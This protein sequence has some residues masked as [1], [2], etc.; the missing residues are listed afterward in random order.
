ML[1]NLSIKVKLISLITIFIVIFIGMNVF[2]DVSLNSQENKFTKMQTVVQIRGNVVGA[3]TSG[4][5]ITSALR[6]VYIN[7]KDHRTIE[8]LEKTVSKMEKY[9]KNLQAKKFLKISQGL[10]KFNIL[11][12][13]DRYDKDIKRLIVKFEAGDL[14]AQD[15]STHI[16]T[17][18]R[19]FKK[20][21]EKY[22]NT[23]K[24]KDTKMT[25]AYIEANSDIF[26]T[27]LVLTIVGVIIILVYSFMITNSIIGSLLKVQNGLVSFFDFLNRKSTQVQSIQIDTNDELGKMSN[28]INHN[29]LHIKDSLE[30]DKLFLEDVN[31]VMTRVSKGWLTQHIKADTDNENLSILKSTINNALENLKE[32]V[33]TINDVLEEYANEDYRK[34]LELNNIEKDGVFDTLVKDINK[35]QQAITNMLLQNKK[36]GTT[37]E[38]SSDVLLKNVS[39]LNKNSNEAAIALEETSAALEDVIG[40]IS[41]NTQNILKMSNFANDVTKS[42]S[43][44]QTLSS[45]TT[46]AMD[47]INEQVTAIND[48]ISVIDQISF[49]TN[50]LSLNAAVEAATAGEAG[51]GFAVVAQEVRNLASRSAEAANEIKT[52]VENA[53]EK[54]NNGKK[55]SD[56]MIAGY[57]VLNQSISNTLELIKDVEKTSKEQQA[58]ILQINDAVSS[59]DKQTQENASVAEQTNTIALQTDKMAKLVVSNVNKKK[60]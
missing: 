44:G 24:K 10:K 19:P 13:Y 20:A 8:N 36:N 6:G 37:L 11:P 32:N 46:T 12:L 50:I 55:I 25:D 56:K 58:S 16:V 33:V 21:L 15:I 9:I 57:E 3:L 51:K 39:V 59:L 48:A 38:K 47:E 49:Q 29:I 7:S 60:F 52:L 28:I 41:N 35:L 14:Q 26:T 53:N 27:L 5:Q 18:W 17:V 45:E 30:Q 34:T 40:K 1:N 23:S 2:T 22:R 43:E 31:N 42:A 54:A 4:L